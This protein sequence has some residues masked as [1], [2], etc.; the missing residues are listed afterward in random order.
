MPRNP[1]CELCPLHEGAHTVCV[2]GEWRGTHAPGL[3]GH[4]TVM[5]VGQS[6]GKREDWEG[7][8]W[9][10]PA[11]QM[12]T[13]ALRSAGILGYYATNAAKCS[14][15]A[16][17]AEIDRTHWTACADYLDEEIEQVQPRF[18]LAL[19]NPAIQR[20]TGKGRVSEVA[21]KEVWSARYQA[22][23]V[24]AF[25]PAAILR[26]QG[27]KPGWLA[28]IFRFGR[29]VRGEIDPPPNTPPV[30][31][32]LVDTQA[33]LHGLTRLLTTEPGF[34][35]DFEA[36]I[37]DKKLPGWCDKRY[38]PYSV[39]FS[40]TGGDAYCVPIAHPD[41]D[42]SWTRVSLT[43]MRALRSIMTAPYGA[44]ID[45]NLTGPRKGVHNI[46]YEGP[47]WY[48]LTG[49]HPYI[50]YDT[51]PLL[52]L[53]DENA[54]KSLKWAGRALLGWPDWDIDAR[55]LWPL[56]KLYPYNGY[57]AA[58]TVNL[59]DYLAP[60]LAEDEWLAR[61]WRELEMPKLRMLVRMVTN[62][63]YVDRSRIARNLLAAWR[64]QGV[65]DSRVPVVNPGSDTQI[66]RWLYEDL[67]LPVLKRGKKHGSTD[68]DTIKKLAKAGHQAGR[69]V[70]DCRRPRKEI[71][72]YYRP[73]G[74]ASRVSFDLRYH[75]D[76]RTTSVETGRLG[77]GFHTTPRPE[78]SALR[79]EPAVRPIFSAPEGYVL[80]QG[81]YSQVEARLCSWSA[82]GRPE[83]LEDIRPEMSRMLIAFAQNRD[84][85]REQ[86]AEGIFGPN[87]WVRWAEIDKNQRQIMG[88]VPVLAMLYRI[89]PGGLQE[90][91]WKEYEIDWTIRQATAVHSA[92]HRLWPEFQRW[93]ALEEAKLRNRGWARSPLGRVRRLP[94]AISGQHD[95]IRAGI[96]APIQSCASDF[97]Q[98]AG[99]ICQRDIDAAPQLD[100]K[101]VG[102]IHDALLVQAPERRAL[103][104]ARWLESR[105]R[106]APIALQRLGLHIPPGLIK[107]EV[108][109]G[110]WGEGKLPAEWA[111]QHGLTTLAA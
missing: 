35:F 69:L 42:L 36:N 72:T 2:W 102:D 22:W 1:G 40:F 8:P 99:V 41:V 47:V 65:A 80:L 101:L 100:L 108:T 49:Y 17:D 12:M 96:N 15:E 5:V 52:H 39:A 4:P 110:P 97:T 111:R 44:R 106:Q 7:H 59:W 103:Q 28:D 75:P 54:P 89:S 90:Y 62:G 88:K 109:I 95:D 38:R 34:A 105:M 66:A 98:E 51:M 107:V 50:D 37:P 67:K 24:A 92:F 11:G 10:G 57:D 30:R 87:Q 3:T 46:M 58:A 85:Y 71:S 81:D 74:R 27:R 68:E 14:P 45:K 33:S 84:I 78:E 91:A 86:A 21:G 43:W 23:I 6:P 13:E 76:I 61:Y 19:G 31:V 9:I 73:I 70:L 53:L 63:I 16:N 18:I 25:H 83:R 104:A 26:A 60:R 32:E 64:R 82:A 48:R 93:H 55:K 20:L 56:Q 79:G 29:L 77:S 94:G